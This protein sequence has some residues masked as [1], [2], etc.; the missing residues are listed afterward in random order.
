MARCVAVIKVKYCK[1]Q[2]RR[3]PCLA[4]IFHVLWPS[5]FYIFLF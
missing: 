1:D 2:R 5:K 4:S 3:Q